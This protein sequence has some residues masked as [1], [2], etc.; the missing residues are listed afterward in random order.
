MFAVVAALLWGCAKKAPEAA[1]PATAGGTA[2]LVPASERSPHFDAVNRHLELG[3]TLYGY[4]DVDGDVLAFASGMQLM[5][6]QLA[7]TQPQF[8]A[9]GR[10]NLKALFSNLGLNDIKAVGF[11]SVREASG[12]FRNRTFIYMPKGRHGIFAALGGQPG[13]FVGEHLAPPDADFFLESE[14]DLGALLDTVKTVVA[15]V[16]GPDAAASLETKLREA[17]ASSG[18]SALDIIQGLN[19]R[20]T[21]I[22]RMDDSGTY[23]APGPVPIKIPSFSA[24]VRV[25]GVGEALVKGLSAS[26]KLVAAR[27]GNVRLFTP[28]EPSGVAGLEPVLAVDGKAFY[29]ATSEAFLHECLKRSAGL[30]TNPE[31]AAGL[32]ALG[33]EGNGAT[34]VTPRFFAKMRAMAAANPQATAQQRRALEVFALHAPVISQPLFSVRTNLPDGI[35]VRSNWNHS[36]KTNLAII[37]IYNP[38]TVGLM[39]AIAIPAFQRAR[40]ASQVHPSLGRGFNQMPFFPPTPGLP[41]FAPVGGTGLVPTPEPRSKMRD[42]LDVVNNLYTLD[43]AAKKY[44]I[45][46]KVDT[47]TYAEL[48]GP[49]KAISEIRPVAG[50]DYTALVFSKG[51]R[52]EVHLSDGRVVRYPLGSSASGGAKASR[53]ASPPT[54]A[55]AP[56]P[57]NAEGRTIVQN[58][59]ILT[60][61]AN[62]Y[63]SDHDATSTTFDQLVG[64]DRYVPS[65]PSIEGED[66]RSLLFLKGRPLRLHLKDGREV[67]YPPQA[68]Q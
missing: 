56:A 50:E 10:Q 1:A 27:D 68:P 20:L 66:Y 65:L 21:V 51:Q 35:L 39:A 53:P 33:P 55:P 11:S 28:S 34:W 63:Y 13:R 32:A 54:A 64:P 36:L 6:E 8:S 47:V 3:G 46:N 16:S 19:G 40:Q 29:A 2:A 9:L 60:D 18:Y 17:G 52:V 42:Q 37:S 12:N 22:V 67:V 59:Q 15:Q 14:F 38:V 45:V 44:Y 57:A 4:G 31:F 49:G 61:A 7:A 23:A 25:D 5:A 30:E 58:L 48:V 41:D 26:P 62:R 43:Q 24:L